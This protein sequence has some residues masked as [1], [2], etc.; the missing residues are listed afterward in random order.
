MNLDQLMDIVASCSGQTKEKIKGKDRDRNLVIPRYIFAYVARNKLK[1]T[2]MD[3]ARYLNQHHSTMIYSV[4]KI[5][6]YLYIK[7]E[8]IEPLYLSVMESVKKFS[9][10]P[11]KILLTFQDESIINDV[12]MDIVNK[13][14]CR[15]EKL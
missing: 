2:F 13:Y 4:G 7:D 15:V 11:I 5:E 9:N 14:E 8:L 6:S 10:E 1:A 3:I 12:I